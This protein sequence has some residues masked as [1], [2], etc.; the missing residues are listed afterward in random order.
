MV[1]VPRAAERTAAAPFP[2][3]LPLLLL[4]AITLAA[5]AAIGLLQVFQTTRTTNAGYELRTLER[6]RA[7]LAA[8]VRLLEADVAEAARIERVPVEAVERLGMVAPAKIVRLSVPSPAPRVVPMPE[9]YVTPAPVAEAPPPAWWER[10]VR[11]LPGF[12]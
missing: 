11:R 1:T 3:R 10:L 6:Q 2:Q 5:V 4:A 7:S 12:D 8:E 9:R